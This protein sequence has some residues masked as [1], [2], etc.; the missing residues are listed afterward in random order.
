MRKSRSVCW[1]V[2]AAYALGSFIA[3]AQT[4]SQWDVRPAHPVMSGTNLLP[5]SPVLIKSLGDAAEYVLR[6]RLP[7]DGEG[8]RIRRVEVERAFRAAIGLET[9]PARTPMNPRILAERDR[10][11]Y[12]VENLVFESRPGFP[13]T[14]NL[15]RPKT[16]STQ[17]RPAILSP[18]GHYLS[19]GKT[20]TDVQARCIQLAKMGFIVLSYD[21]IGQGERM[22][23]ENI[24]HDAGY[25]L[26]PLGQTIA[27]WMAWDS[28][29]AIDYLLTRDDVDANRIGVTGN[30]GGGLN[31]LFTA[32]LDSRVRAA[33]V[34]GYTFEFNNW[35][36]YAGSHCTCTH[37][38]GVFR[39]MEWFE[40]AGLIA[41]RPLLMLQGASD[42]IFPISGARR[43]ANN[44]NA[45]YAMMGH[46]AQARFDELP[47]LPHAYTRPYRERMYGWMA[48]HLLG[49]TSAEPIAEGEMQTL[50]E[51]DASL[52]CDPNGSWVPAAPSV[53]GMTQ[54]EASIL[55]A[56]LPAGDRQSLESWVRDL[57]APP[58]AEPHYLAPQTF[59]KS[60]TAGGV[61]EKISFLSEDGQ[62]IP[63]LLWLP[64]GAPPARTIILVSGKGK[65]AIA[66]SGLVQPLLES[67]FAVLA[68]D[69]RGRGE[70]LGHFRERWDTNFRLVANQVLSGRPLAGRRAFDLTRAVD[71]LTRRRLP[72]DGLTVT[73]I[74]DDALPVLLAAATDQRIKNI[75]VSE[76]FHSFLSQMRTFPRQLPNAWNDPQLRG[77]FDTG[78][79]EVDFGSVIPSVLRHADIPDLLALAEP[80]RVL[81][82]D[83]RD[84]NSIGEA[85]RSRFRTVTNGKNVRYEPAAALDA[86]LLLEWI[87]E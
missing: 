18:V 15:Y 76:Y 73:G 2:L 10:G 69:L 52:L 50:P 77:R 71:Y 13:V 30:S 61:M 86:R 80:R 60:P 23:H 79:Y 56:K 85:L 87:G 33:V 20:A 26:L 70:T 29:R 39:N 43:A 4:G 38:P 40:I 75:A 28:M 44:T 14:A 21:A 65:G 7:S 55:V 3:S 66:E 6:W 74:G 37:L 48:H 24:H 12:I 22:R 59:G 67:G 32:A 64:E 35:L 11:E 58:E 47:G 16:S 62:Y 81:F 51:S 19:A 27:G 54:Q 83:A 25:A 53:L 68:V 72:M 57:A 45:I 82:C 78:G 31:T 49:A 17:K 63:G 84:R 46:G 1:S 9:L 41:P 34:V 5:N 8:W 36:K 42:N